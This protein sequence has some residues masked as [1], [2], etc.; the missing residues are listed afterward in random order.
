MVKLI[1]VS[2]ESLT[3]ANMFL[4]ILN[5]IA[6]LRMLR[7]GFVGVFGVLARQTC[8]DVPQMFLW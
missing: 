3:M 1:D 2:L 7:F 8:I 5:P 6:N 4:G